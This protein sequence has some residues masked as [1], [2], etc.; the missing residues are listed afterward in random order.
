LLQLS[1]LHRKNELPELAQQLATTANKL[2][3]NLARLEDLF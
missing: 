1:L 2:E 3:M